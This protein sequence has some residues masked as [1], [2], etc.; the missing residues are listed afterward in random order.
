MYT[1]K[2]EAVNTYED[3]RF[4]YMGPFKDD[5]TVKILVEDA[6]E[7]PVFTKSAYVLEIMEDARINT[8][9]GTVTAQDPDAARSPVK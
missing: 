3:S 2:V 4:Q 1:L 6:D 8:L 5:A 7:P 9:I